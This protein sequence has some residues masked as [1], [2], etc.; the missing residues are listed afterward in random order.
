M[1]KL[2]FAPE[3]FNLAE[4]TRM[5]EVAKECRGRAECFFMGYS[6]KFSG[7]IEKAGFPFYL[8]SPKLDEE[9]IT[10][11]M[12]F[13]QGRSFKIPFTYDMLKER[14]E[15]ELALIEALEIDGVVIGSTVSLF[16]SARV[17]K[18]PLTYV[19]PYVYS[20]SWVE[21]NQFMGKAPEF[22]KKG[23]RKLILSLNYLPK[24]IK[25]IVKEYHVEDHFPTL[26]DSLDGDLNCI[27]TPELLTG[28]PNL[29][30]NSIYVGP[31]FADLPED[32]PASLFQLF[33]ATDDPIIYCSMG[34]SGTSEIVYN[35]L[36]KF[37]GLP[38]QV[39]SPMKSFLSQEQTA[40]L[41]ANIHL[42]DWLPAKQVQQLVTASVLHGGEGTVQTA[43]V[44]GKPF[45]G[46]GLQ[47]EQEY[48]I[49]CCVDYGNAIQLKRKQLKDKEYFKKAAAELLQNPSYQKKA[50]K[51]QQELKSINGSK[52]AAQ[53]ILEIS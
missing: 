38:V 32:I 31:I 36:K 44:A 27:T 45:I 9:T 28:N 35:L 51:L 24:D 48:N 18:I 22:L 3:T 5:I 4:T 12:D 37:A 19:K 42:Y 17:K 6:D 29:S 7:Y 23:G 26:I 10:K 43:C 40:S 47:K 34:S 2:L 8:L 33:R 53:A 1:K 25:K 15:N 16:V 52:L 50:Q 30:K 20:R 41:P 21:G 39:V 11:I 49:K 14:I 46:I 13:D